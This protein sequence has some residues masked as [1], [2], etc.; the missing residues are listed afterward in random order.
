M[1]AQFNGL[2]D[3]IQTIHVGPQG[4]QGDP[5]PEDLSGTAQNPPAV[6]PL[7]M[8]VSNPPTQAEMQA[9]ANKLDELIEVLKR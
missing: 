6:S 9:I 5:G 7:M 8:T 1:R 4:P 2:F 3:L